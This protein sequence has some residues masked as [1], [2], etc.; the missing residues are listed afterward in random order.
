MAP[1]NTVDHH[2]RKER[3]VVQIC[4]S[5]PAARDHL[6][7]L[8]SLCVQASSS[9]IPRSFRKHRLTRASSPSKSR[10]SRKNLAGAINF[11]GSNHSLSEQA[12]H[13]HWP[14]P[15]ARM[16]FKAD[17]PPIHK[18][19]DVQITQI[20]DPFCP[21]VSRFEHKVFKC[22]FP[23][24]MNLFIN[25]EVERIVTGSYRHRTE[26]LQNVFAGYPF[27][28]DGAYSNIN[29]AH[30]RIWDGLHQ[31]P[32]V[33]LKFLWRLTNAV[34]VHWDNREKYW[35][36]QNS[37]QEA[38]TLRGQAFTYTIV[39]T[40]LSEKNNQQKIYGGQ[41]R[42][43]DVEFMKRII[44]QLRKL[45]DEVDAEFE[46]PEEFDQVGLIG[47][48]AASGSASV[49]S[50]SYRQRPTEP[51]TSYRHPIDAMMEI[52][53]SR[54]RG[55]TEQHIS[56]GDTT[57]EESDGELEENNHETDLPY[58]DCGKS[59]KAR[60]LGTVAKGEEDSIATRLRQ[61]DRRASRGR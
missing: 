61:R 4:S 50:G 48:I 32:R 11:Q 13:S 56:T 36:R 1:G 33:L 43:D 39:Y 41:F 58:K 21:C 55:P 16:I 24:H 28:D 42:D 19:S 22:P 54:N 52:M 2:A 31:E 10:L 17:D 25:W 51:G 47:H 15:W 6:P 40:K 9:P 7:Q 45:V 49:A 12:K 5:P 23:D 29:Y 60:G 20:P 3:P 35:D 53:E 30:P 57:D 46:E 38:A 59:A 37:Q 44:V 8:S 18:F 27:I 26:A 14:L 34:L